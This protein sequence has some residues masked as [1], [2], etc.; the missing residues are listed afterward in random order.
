MRIAAWLRPLAGADLED[1]FDRVFA[2][3]IIPHLVDAMVALAKYTKALGDERNAFAYLA[4]AIH[5]ATC[6]RETKDK[7]V[8]F[9]QQ[10]ESHLSHQEVQDMVQWAKAAHIE[11]VAHDWL[12]SVRRRARGKHPV[13]HPKR[14][15][16]ALSG[17]NRYSV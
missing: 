10:L 14:K 7:I 12:L 8:R 17:K 5:H 6:R 13:E 11:D 4:L 1:A 9:A 16:S 3:R 15:V 2:F